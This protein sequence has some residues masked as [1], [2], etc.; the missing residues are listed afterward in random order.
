MGAEPILDPLLVR[1]VLKTLV[2]PPAGPLFVALAGLCLLRVRP[3]L[4][5]IL[6]WVGAGGL[7]L[8][9]IPIVALGLHRSVDQSP[10]FDPARAHDAQA[11]VILGSGVRR[12]APEWGG[13][14]LGPRTLERV[15]YGARLARNT[16][17]PVLV[18]GGTIGGGASEARLMRDC[19]EQE[20]AVQVRWMEA[21][22]R[23]THENA[24]D[25]AAVLIPAGVRTVVLVAH[26]LDMPR[27]RA[28]FVAAGLAVIPAPI[29]LPTHDIDSPLDFL[30]GISGLTQSYIA[31]YE[32]LGE[33]VRRVAR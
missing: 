26:S 21:A 1:A 30:P 22:S 29:G 17:L 25:T 11:L 18:S 33:A 9:S 3:R 14:T 24:V 19:L 27:A 13:D 6:A 20:F 5:R 28:E 2:L 15:R 32:A 16:G 12:H 8:L 4:G 7:L 10:V 31:L 23:N